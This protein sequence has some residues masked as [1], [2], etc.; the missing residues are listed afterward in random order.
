MSDAKHC[1]ECGAPLPTYWPKGLCAQCALDG[2]LALT[3]AESQVLQQK[4]LVDATD[5]KFPVASGDNPTLGLFGD[6]ELLEEIARG[7]MGVVY[8]ARQTSLGRIVAVKMI[9]AGPLAGKE[10]VQRFRTEASAAAILQHPNIVAI[11]DVGVHEGRHFFSMDHV[12]GQNL[13]QLV[14]QQPLPANKAARYVE[15]IAQAIHYAHGRGILHRDLKPSNVLI[16]AATDQPRVTDFGLAKRLDGESSLTMSGQVL[17]SPNF[18]PPEQAGGKRGKVGRTSDVYALGGILYYLLTAR[19]PFRADSLEQII[20][21]V[22][23]AEP[24]SP[25]LLN[26]SVP[27]DL[28]TITL[29]CLEKEPS[30]R[31]QTAKELADE[32]SRV[33]RQ[34]PI[35]A[36]PVNAPEKLWRWCRR[37]PALA[38]AVVFAIAAL[39]IGLATTSWQWR[40]AERIAVSERHE[41]ER[42]QAQAYVSDMN[43]VH[44]ALAE[45][46]LGRARQLL[47]R[48]RPSFGVPTL[49]GS[50]QSRDSGDRLRA[51]HET[52]LRGWEWRY[53]WQR[54]RGDMEFALFRQAR[55]VYHAVFLSDGVRVATFADPGKASLWDVATRTEVAALQVPTPHEFPI[56]NSGQA[57]FSTDGELLATRDRDENGMQ[58]VKVWKISTGE[59]MAEFP[60]GRR[61]VSALTFSPD[62]QRLAAFT[63]EAVRVWN[64]ST[65]ELQLKLPVAPSQTDLYSHGAVKFSPDGSLLAIGDGD[66]RIRLVNVATGVE[67]PPFNASSVNG[68]FTLAFS[69]D[70]GLLAAGAAYD[71]PAITVWDVSRRT[72]VCS[73][74]GHNGFIGFLAFSPDGKTLASASGDATIKLWTTATWKEATTLAGHA[75]EVW[76]VDFSTNGQRLVSAGKDGA[77]YLWPTSPMQFDH[78][79]PGLHGGKQSWD[80]SPDSTALAVVGRDGVVSL[81]NANTGQKTMPLSALGTNNIAVFWSPTGEILAGSRDSPEIKSWNVS[82]ATLTTHPLN[83][84]EPPSRWLF[85][86]KTER[87]LIGVDS[88]STNWTFSRWDVRTRKEVS[89]LTVNKDVHD[90]AVSADE[91]LVVIGTVQGE[92]LLLNLDTGQSEGAFKAHA[93][94]MVRGLALLPDGKFLVT[95]GTD[96][97]SLKVWDLPTRTIVRQVRAHN[98]IIGRIVISPDGSRLATTSI[99]REPMKVWDTR[100]WE[101]VAR[102][103]V[104]GQALSMARFLPDGNTLAATD[105]A[106]TIHLWRAPTFDQIVAA[107]EPHAHTR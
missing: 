70:G 101:E 2:A 105:A 8:K 42:A 89:T 57:S 33:L 82:N 4:T 31:Y 6:Y 32:L 106:G 61:L 99:G 14:G 47:D 11:H 25:R 48:H 17:G 59:V 51:G 5:L 3:N 78:E 92:V 97:P 21:Q 23:N 22:I 102:I 24:I 44:Q 52:D 28:E 34:E 27:R 50:A 73:L 79:V 16:D 88:Q 19:A 13:A 56:A 55:R 80:V 85:L 18:M 96:G 90:L 67:S 100:T 7:G 91:R 39:L 45:H 60:C 38:S 64:V 103:A 36:R 1:A 83:V 81:W 20:T 41:R 43:A 29:K 68:I 95:A 71:D 35:Q 77:V 94:E 72:R 10:F 69:P 15:L 26:P 9:L 30:R 93:P 63:L 87:L 46:D 37:K 107:E 75:D 86:S 84:G 40:R 104:E 12:E 74:Q 62:K 76:S 53:L 54:A 58:S 66:G 98:L 49:A 65:K